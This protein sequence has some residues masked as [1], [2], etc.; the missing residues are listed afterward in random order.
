MEEKYLGKITHAEFG[1]Y[2]DRPF[3]FGLQ[4]CFEFNRGGV[5]DGARYTVNI[6]PECR[7]EEFER[8]EA[9]KNMIE[10]LD[11]ILT[12]AKVNHV[13]KLKNKPVEVTL[14]NNTFKDFRILTEV[15]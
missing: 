14:Y 4:L 15:I 13:S 11:K 12:D 10:H 9:I 8:L 2:P 5:C 6:S 1:Q 7:W 3:L